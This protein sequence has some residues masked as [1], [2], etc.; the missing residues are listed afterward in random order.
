M[1][2]FN[3]KGDQQK[4]DE[5]HES[6]RKMSDQIAA[7]A[8]TASEQIDKIIAG[9]FDQ[10]DK[11][12]T[13]LTENVRRIA[14]AMITKDKAN[15]GMG[16]T[17]SMNNAQSIIAAAE[18][19][20]HLNQVN[21]RS[22]AMAAAVEELLAS[23]SQ[24]VNSSENTAQLAQTLKDNTNAVLEYSQKASDAMS[25]INASM[26]NVD[27][28]LQE[29]TSAAAGID[30]MLGFIQNIADK[31][32]MLALNATIE[33]ARAGE[34]GKGFAVVAGEVKNLASQTSKATGDIQ[35]RTDILRSEVSDIEIV[36]TQ[37]VDA[38]RDGS[39]II[40]QSVENTQNIGAIIDEVA[41]ASNDVAYISQEQLSAAN[42]VAQGTTEVASLADRCMVS[43]TTLISNMQKTDQTIA[44]MLE[45]LSANEFASRDLLRA[46]A[47][48]M[49]WRKNLAEMLIGN[50]SLNPDELKDHHSCRLGKWY[51][52]LK[53]T[54][55]ADHPAYDKLLVP[56]E[57]V[58][59][60]GIE[61]AS[62]FEQGDLDG[63]IERV[64]AIEAPSQLVQQY[65]DELIE[66][67]EG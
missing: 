12:D 10:V 22:Q 58:H 35:S 60:L 53:G 3:Q 32:N 55:L 46:K 37:S 50:A 4:L 47:D 7:E 67:I 45:Q 15:L 24:V 9:Q 19:Q 8:Y 27:L 14:D 57:E 61:A 29:L 64:K 54:A 51:D 11:G 6:I 2:G 65:I 39:E 28:K 34:A 30:E 1:L 18:T 52:K 43:N 40:S 5:L 66:H 20:D 49:I 36:L 17:L 23:F 41:Q 63:A 16:V 59:R 25:R 48:H 26:A 33:A 42:E 38:V 13:V 31:T 56:H 62:V 44:D 21:H